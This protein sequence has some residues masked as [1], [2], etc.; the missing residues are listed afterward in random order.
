MFE[1]GVLRP[2]EPLDLPENQRVTLTIE[3]RSRL[4]ASIHE[5]TRR[6]PWNPRTI[7]MRWL[8]EHRNEYPGEW[9]A[10]GPEGLV[11]HGRDYDLVRKEATSKGIDDPLIDHVPLEPDLPSAGWL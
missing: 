6:V 7:E 5:S 1:N 3:D 11:A 4:A 10:L 9:L 8:A 2:V